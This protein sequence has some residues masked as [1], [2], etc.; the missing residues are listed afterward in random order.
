MSPKGCQALMPSGSVERFGC[1]LADQRRTRP[2]RGGADDG[3]GSAFGAE[4]TQDGGDVELC[5][6]LAANS[7]PRPAATG[8][9]VGRAEIT[10]RQ[11]D[12]AGGLRAPA[13]C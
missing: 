3:V 13:H 4:L 9:A 7:S 1:R 8:N 11:C 10:V 2:A 5:G 12:Y 6:V